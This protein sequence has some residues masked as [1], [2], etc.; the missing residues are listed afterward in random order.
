[1]SFAVKAGHQGI[2]KL[3]LD[4]GANV[5]VKDNVGETA[6]MDAVEY[7]NKEIVELYFKTMLM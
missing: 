2:V 6:L 5:N 7:G 1:M 3:L 4:S